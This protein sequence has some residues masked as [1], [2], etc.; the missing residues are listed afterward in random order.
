MKAIILAGG[1]G[2]RLYPLT[3]V[4]S[5]QLQAVY[6]KPMIYYPLTVLIAS[7]IRQF[8]LITTPQDLPRF[9]ALLGDGSRWGISIEYREQPRPDGIAQAFVIAESFIGKD[10]VVLM[11][12]DNI[13]FGGDAFPRAIAGFEAGATIFA[14][15]VKDPQRYGVVEFDRHGH[16]LSIEEKPQSPRSNYAVPGVY[17]YDNQVVD[18]A[19]SLT[20]SARGELEITDVNRVYLERGQLDV[21][22]LSRGFAW[23]DAGTSSAL[24]EASSY[25]QTIEKRQDVKIG[26]PEEAAL[27]RG[28]LTVEQLEALLATMPAC[29]YREYLTRVAEETRR[30][31]QGR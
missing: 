25:I 11:L 1:A 27:V 23:L 14:Y 29:E 5:K 20:P 2:S 30:F 7:G 15:H 12:G 13:F 22:R 4:A 17:I 24:Q 28:F 3:L 19:K 6:D 10:K 26:C 16:A 31:R 8:C 18:I 9:E 21:H